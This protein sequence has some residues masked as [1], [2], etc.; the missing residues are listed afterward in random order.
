MNRLCKSYKTKK[1]PLISNREIQGST[2]ARGQSLL[3]RK[4]NFKIMIHATAIT[5]KLEWWNDYSERQSDQ[6][7]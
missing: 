1:A 2:P 3:F 5:I 6:Q 7:S 4:A